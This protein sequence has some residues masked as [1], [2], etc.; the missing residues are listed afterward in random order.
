VEGNTYSDTGLTA[1]GHYY[2]V[3]SPVAAGVEGADSAEA[4]ASTDSPGYFPDVPTGLTVNAGDGQVALAWRASTGATSY[5]VKR[6]TSSG[7][8]FLTVASGVTTA[9]YIDSS[10]T[11]GQL[12]YYTVSAMSGKESPNCGEVSDLP[13]SV[14]A[15]LD[16]ADASGVVVTGAWT[17]G[18]GSP[19]FYG[20]NYLHDGNAGATGGKSVRFT[21]TLPVSGSYLVAVRWVAATNR[22][23]NAPI[24][25]VHSAGTTTFTANQW[26]EGS[27]WVP[28]GVFNFAA[29]ATGS[30]VVRNDGANGYVIAD[31]VK[32]TLTDG[33]LVAPAAPSDLTATPL[34]ANDIALTW[35]NH[36]IAE[37]GFKLDRATN[38]TFTQNLVTVTLGAGA[39]SHQSSGLSAGVT[40]YFRVRAFD[41]VAGQ[42]PNSNTAS[43]TTLGLSPPAAPGNLAAATNSSSQIDL[44]WTDDATNES[45]FEL[46][47]ATDAAFGANLI[48]TTLAA[49]TSSRSVTGLT[50]ATTYYFRLRAVNAAGISS[51]TT[52]AS[53]TTAPASGSVSVTV[54]VNQQANGS[55]WN[56]VGT[57]YFAA[58]AEGFVKIRTTGTSGYVVAD[59]V[60]FSLSGQPDV[61]LD[62]ETANAVAVVGD[63]TDSTGTPG[64]WGSSYKHDQ[65]ADKGNKSVTYTPNLPVAG[66]WTISLYW[67]A[68]SNRASNVPVDIIH[69]VGSG[70][71]APDAPGSLAVSSVTASSIDLVWT[72]QAQN[73]T[74][75]ELQHAT[76]AAFT[77]NVISTTLAADA[78]SSSVTS[79]AAGTTY[80]LRVRATN[81][82]GPSAW[83]NA[84]SATTALADNLTTKFINQQAGGGAWASL[85]SF[86]FNAGSAGSVKIRTDG[87]SGYVVA[88]A[89]KFTLSGQPDIVLD[90]EN[91][92]GITIVGAWN[93]SS[94]SPGYLGASYKHDQ[95]A[96][97]GTKSI[98]FTPALPVAGNWT[99]S[100]RWTSDPNRSSRVP[101]DILYDPTANPAAASVPPP[102]APSGLVATV[103]TASG[104]DLTWTDNANNE[105]AFELQQASD[106]AFTAGLA[107]TPLASG[108]SSGSVTG[109]P[110]GA[111]YYFRVRVTNAAGASAWSGSASAAIKAQPVLTWSA[112]PAIPYGTALGATQ[113][114][115]TADVPGTFDYLP[116]AG[117]FP[118]AGAGQMLTVVFTPS[119]TAHYFTASASTSITVNPA[120]ATVTL[121]GLTQTY[122][123][124]PKNV[125]AFTAP[126]GLTVDLTYD[127]SPTA[128]MYPGSYAVA[129]TIDDPNY[130][131]SAAG[132][133]AIDVSALVRHGPTL[134]STAGIDGSLQVLQAENVT[135]NSGAWISGDLLMPGTPAVV[136]NGSPVYAGVRDGTGSAA[137]TTHRLTLNGKSLLRYA[138]RRIDPIAMPVIATPAAPQGTR[139][140]ALNA[141][142]QSPGSFATLRSLTLNSHA[143]TVV[144]PPGVYGEFTANRDT[145]L[146]LGVAGSTQPAVYQFQRFTLNSG[147]RIEIVGPVEITLASQL[148]L[149]SG[150]RID[151]QPGW[152]VVRVATA[153]VTLHGDSSLCGQV[154]A[155]LGSITLN[156]TSQI[157]GTVI[158]DQ[159][160]LNGNGRVIDP[161]AESQ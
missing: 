133:L 56:S 4:G 149:N 26:Y 78:T 74:G 140:V 40:Y 97:K 129:A 93:D 53:A 122:D 33:S 73:E 90:S 65:N 152:L 67:T 118:N 64:Y 108:A 68:A 77:A 107:T 132:T 29:G 28:V 94:S 9:S 46:Q 39:N 148:T 86:L 60:K 155:P 41:T 128:P 30:V 126:S 83:S 156:N 71:V 13:S 45:S 123:G 113:L 143:G 32:F 103:N 25:V 136:A 114:N 76:D 112:P 14:T 42:S 124:T 52:A 144:V 110:A 137:P 120:A 20:T 85:G 34:S 6:A 44:T 63:W 134:N 59:A 58:G 100:V 81:D 151:A 61:M 66:N 84:V 141:P 50:A 69:A 24:D 127:D 159:L 117:T 121:G 138:V 92:A 1:S 99:V 157:R 21:P 135:L 54:T 49:D 18:T 154:I 48:T 106:S 161:A 37:N 160:I 7:G 116:A 158:C 47:Q 72:D 2:Y 147:A 95:N 111:T 43:A 3:V 75:F 105:D 91:A 12:Y 101:V 131:G 57:H 15:I 23:S 139:D 27:E 70:A 35:I 5:N 16:N 104:I 130:D 96:D 153:G 79:L 80:Y 98:T 22:A 89:V 88:D 8:P 87:T 10:A 38:A 115:A 19:G 62:S 55:A 51:W 142:G 36:S 146:V 102:A 125:T 31:A 109:L 119:D 145:T 11:N 150:A 82:A 17:A